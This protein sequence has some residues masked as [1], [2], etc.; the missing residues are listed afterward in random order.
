M[1]LMALCVEKASDLI[2]WTE[3][4]TRRV[5]NSAGRVS[6]SAG[7]VSNSAGRVSIIYERVVNVLTTQGDE[8]RCPD[9]HS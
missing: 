4:T 2:M 9:R 6:N 1:L 7:R 3:D 5:S 8:L